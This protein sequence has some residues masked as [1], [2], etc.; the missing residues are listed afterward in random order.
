MKGD[1]E[2]LALI[3]ALDADDKAQSEIG[4][5]VGRLRA[6]QDR[7]IRDMEAAE[8]LPLGAET[9][10]SRQGCHKSTL[11][12]RVSRFQKVARQKH[13]ATNP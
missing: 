4:E 9:A 3:A 2:M 13:N 5:T 8:L 11:Y 1:A 6:R 7:A 10:C 12:R